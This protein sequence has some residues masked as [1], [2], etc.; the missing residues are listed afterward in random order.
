MDHDG[1]DQASELMD[2]QSLELK[3]QSNC[4]QRWAFHLQL[5]RARNVAREVVR[6]ADV[7]VVLRYS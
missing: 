1:E 7:R 2:E 3:S 4:A 6:L 5:S